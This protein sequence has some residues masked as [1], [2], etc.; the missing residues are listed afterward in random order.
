VSGILAALPPPDLSALKLGM[1]QFVAQL[2]QVGERLT[3]SRDGMGLCLWVMAGAAAVTACEMARRQL[4][5]EQR[6]V[7]SNVAN[8]L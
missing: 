1:Q 5:R 8:G 2:E 6:P 4:V 7:A 3:G